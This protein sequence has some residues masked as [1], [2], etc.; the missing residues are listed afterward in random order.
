MNDNLKATA[1]GK[2]VTTRLAYEDAVE[3]LKLLLKDEG[4]GVLCDIDVR[5]TL[6]EKIGAE[7]R[8]YRILGACNP[9]YAHQAL[10]AES[11]LGLL[12]PCNVVVQEEN[13]TTTVSAIDVRALMQVVGKPAL[14]PIA[15][16]VN[17]SLQRVLD[18]ISM[19]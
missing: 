1:Y 19:M 3:R 7:F 10:T 17:A 6:K 5:T 15:D 13:G 4:F 16:E 9:T 8:P 11:Q 14:L 12:L 2:A 18:K